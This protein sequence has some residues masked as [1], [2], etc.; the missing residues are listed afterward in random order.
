MIVDIYNFEFVCK[1]FQKKGSRN[2][3]YYLKIN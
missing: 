2:T 1:Y 3:I